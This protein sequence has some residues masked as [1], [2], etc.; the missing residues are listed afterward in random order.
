MNTLKNAA[1]LVV[2]GAVLY[3]V[4]V[5]LNKPQL[6]PAST[7]LRHQH[8]SLAPPAVE[9][10]TGPVIQQ[11]PANP[12]PPLFA[13][14]PLATL[15]PIDHGNSAPV[16]PVAPIAPIAH[17]AP[18]VNPSINPSEP[19]LPPPQG[20]PLR[21]AY[22]SPAVGLPVEIAPVAPGGSRRSAYEAPGVE[23][24]TNDA[25]PVAPEISLA[26]PTPNP[27]IAKP[28][29]TERN[30][31]LA[32]YAL[33][34]D[35][36]R[37]E[38][39][40]QANRYREALLILTPHHGNPDFSP[41]DQDV[42]HRW[43]DALAGKVIY[44]SE[45]LL[46]QPHKVSRGE[47]LLSIGEQYQ[48]PWSLLQNVNNV[49]DPQVLVAGTTLKIVPGPFRAEVSLARKELTLLVQDLYAGRFPFSLGDEPPLPGEY[50][51]RDKSRDRPY[52]TRDNRTIYGSD[53]ANPYGG[54]WIDLGNGAALHGSSLSANPR[55][56][57]LGSIS[58]SPQDA[59][60]IFAIVSLGSP[61]VVRK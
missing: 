35:F 36:Q 24:A 13:A 55:T 22:E 27:A 38:E 15:P 41:E 48:V 53:P 16:A 45:H 39:A 11:P 42:L 60:D 8:E 30:R 1:L 7:Q 4:Y 9:I 19:P 61:V 5:T 32:A 51:V 49:R 2:M 37:A 28:A 14:A 50:V 23:I 17:Q 31:S 59:R 29:P 43:L 21:S 52:Y 20:N 25:P 54:Y 18:I 26:T 44:S 46:A 47:T 58:F 12:P 10:S 57:N 34:Q 33:K 3:F 40:V 6:S 56:A